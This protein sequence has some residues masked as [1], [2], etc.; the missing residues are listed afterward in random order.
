MNVK[1]YIVEVNE[2]ISCE[3]YFTVT[4]LHYTDTVALSQNH[5]THYVC[6]TELVVVSG[7]GEMAGCQHYGDGTPLIRSNHL[8]K[9]KLFDLLKHEGLCLIMI[10]ILSTMCV[11]D[12]DYIE[13]KPLSAHKNVGISLSSF[14][15]HNKYEI[16][17]L[18]CYPYRNKQQYYCN[19]T[20]TNENS[21][22]K[23][24]SPLPE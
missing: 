15:S 8:Q 2:A 23:E 20:N 11:F 18:H 9:L 10:R 5:S 4:S 13:R 16:I 7:R 12:K 3:T 17:T 24:V 6:V 1:K 21:L 19:V 22:L 14:D